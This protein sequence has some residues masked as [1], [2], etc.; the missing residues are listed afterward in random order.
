MQLY[1]TPTRRWTWNILSC[2]G[3]TEMY[4]TPEC[5]LP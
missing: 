5:L 3:A 1:Y 4:W 2:L